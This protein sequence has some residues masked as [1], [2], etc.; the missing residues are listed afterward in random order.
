MAVLPYSLNLDTVV[1]HIHVHPAL[2]SAS[3]IAVLFI[4]HGHPASAHH[5]KPIVN[6][7]FDLVTKKAALRGAQRNLVIITFVSR[8]VPFRPRMLIIMLL[9]G[10]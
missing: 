10:H 2:S 9:I 5:M 8:L 6:G 3:N 4:L 7:A 1:A